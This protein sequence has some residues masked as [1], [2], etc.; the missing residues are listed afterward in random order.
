MGV[1]FPV[2]TDKVFESIGNWLGL[3]HVTLGLLLMFLTISMIAGVSIMLVVNYLFGDPLPLWSFI[4][5]GLAAA[6]AYQALRGSFTS[7]A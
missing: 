3:L 5:I 6:V 4:P 1:V 7:D 2:G